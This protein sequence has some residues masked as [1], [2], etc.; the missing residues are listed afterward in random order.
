MLFSLVY[1]YLSVCIISLFRA[2]N[3]EKNDHFFPANIQVKTLMMNLL[4]LLAI[5]YRVYV[6][7]LY[8]Y[9][10][11]KKS[12]VSN[13]ANCEHKLATLKNKVSFNSDVRYLFS[14]SL[15]F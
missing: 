5:S 13:N 4:G 15:L 3:R 7:Q 2:S 14:I 10:K 6:L 11:A 1:V 9:Y 8:M 12:L